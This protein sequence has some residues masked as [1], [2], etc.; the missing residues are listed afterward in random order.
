MVP[1]VLALCSTMRSSS[2]YPVMYALDIPLA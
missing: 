1:Y 2:F